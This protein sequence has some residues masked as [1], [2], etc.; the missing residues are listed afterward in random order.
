MKTL[1]TSVCIN[2][3][4]AGHTL[5]MGRMAKKLNG[6]TGMKTRQEKLQLKTKIIGLDANTLTKTQRGV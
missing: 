5:L 1:L 6:L 3:Q 4:G 2:Q